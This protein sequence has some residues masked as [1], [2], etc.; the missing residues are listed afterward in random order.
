MSNVNIKRLVEN[1]RS[2]TTVY[3]PVIELIVNGIQAIDETSRKDGKINVRV[4]RGRQGELDGSLPEIVGFEVEDN[5]IGFTEKHSKSFDTLYTDQKI[6]EGGKGFGRFVGLKY[7]EDLHVSSVYSDGKSLKSRSFSMGKEHEIIVHQ[8]V[9]PSNGTSTGST[10]TLDTLKEG[11]HKFDKTLPTVARYLVERLLPYFIT[12]GYTCPEIVLAEQDGSGSIRLNDYVSSK[13]YDG[14]QEISIEHKTFCIEAFKEVE[15]FYVRVFKLYA[16]RNQRSRISLVAH[17]REV[18]G[19]PLQEYIP[20][21]A[22]D[23]FEADQTGESG[24]ERNYI[25]KAYVFGAY[26]DRNVSLERGG[27]EF[28]K[29]VDLIYGIS[30]TQIEQNAARI[31][32][33]AV[34]TEI[35]SRQQ[36][37]LERVR[38]YVDKQA[39][40]HK[41]I[42]ENID[43]SSMPY[44]PTADEI[45]ALL[46]REKFA[47]EVSIRRDVAV[48]LAETNIDRF[49]GSVAKIVRKVSG[50][51]KNEL[52][53]YI[54]LR[55][56]VLDIFEKSLES[57]ESGVYSREKVIHDI[58]FPQKGNSDDTPYHEHNLW[59]IDE[60]LTFTAFVSSDQPIDSSNKDRPDI[61]VYDH[62]VLFRGDNEPSNPVTIFEFKRPGRDDF[63]NPSSD[64]DPV[65]QIVRY[66]NL[67]IDGNEKTLN[68]RRIS[69]ANNTPFYGYIVCDLTPKVERWIE[70]EKDFQAMPDRQGWYKWHSVNN[71][72][73]EVLSWDKVLKDAKMRNQIFFQKLGIA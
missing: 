51:S 47:Q 64:D 44:N 8:Q 69:V 36:R 27:F 45:E 24:R 31:A 40:W 9:T 17:K 11:N 15:E 3:T 22:D 73:I 43:L 26:L 62:R 52:I 23:F 1:I 39:P 35:T 28:S 5:G 46:N 67:L 55:R 25:I 33:E 18:P 63:A 42:L 68:G 70:R 48:L 4:Q 16:P 6:A 54:A 32:R 13:L 19:S 30:Q 72:Y 12:Q 71:L 20:E 49:K 2:N 60:R 14:I 65:K 21:F 57:D 10:V 58:I 53:H 56:T 59:M 66:V 41:T 50:R 37:K 29:D 61:L 34:G 38:T 7:F